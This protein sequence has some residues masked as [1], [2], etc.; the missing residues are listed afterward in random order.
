ML[1]SEQVSSQVLDH[2]G[3]VMATI[4]RVG[5]MDKIDQR[6]PL[7]PNKGAIVKYGAK[8]SGYDLEWPWLYR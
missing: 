2:L 3:L 6:L 7:H 1:K 5:L 4:D 8:S